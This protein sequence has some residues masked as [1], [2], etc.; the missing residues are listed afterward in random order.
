MI[1]YFK[2]KYDS[3]LFLLVPVISMGKITAEEKKEYELNF[4][5][6]D[7]FDAYAFRNSKSV[8]ISTGVLL[9]FQKYFGANFSRDHIAAVLAH[10]LQH[11]MQSNKKNKSG[12]G[13][14]RCKIRS[15]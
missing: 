3:T 9:E 10:E 13:I 2:A 14:G 4:F 15:D 6:S 1:P 12:F 5:Y 8:F 7:N 11:T